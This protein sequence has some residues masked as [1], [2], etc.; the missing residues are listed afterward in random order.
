MRKVI[1][2]A[3]VVIAYSAA[4]ILLATVVMVWTTPTVRSQDPCRRIFGG[5]GFNDL[6]SILPC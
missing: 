4:Y 5:M 6:A 1:P 2:K 3:A